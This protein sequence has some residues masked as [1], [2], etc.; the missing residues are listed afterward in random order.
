MKKRIEGIIIIAVAVLAGIGAFVFIGLDAPVLLVLLL[1]A[2]LG[3]GVSVLI[4]GNRA[5]NKSKA[6][7]TDDEI[8][9]SRKLHEEVNQEL[10]HKGKSGIEAINTIGGVSTNNLAR[11]DKSWSSVPDFFYKMI[12]GKDNR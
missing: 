3:I 11:K 8:I 4:D 10:K 7:R 2:M 5:I 12:K 9:N 6:S 1:I